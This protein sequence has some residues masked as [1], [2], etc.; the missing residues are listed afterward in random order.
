MSTIQEESSTDVGNDAPESQSQTTS[1]LDQARK[2]QRALI[3]AMPSSIAN[4]FTRASVFLPV[5]S[6][7]HAS[8][9]GNAPLLRH[10]TMSEL[11]PLTEGE[12]KSKER[13]GQL[14]HPLMGR[15][16]SLGHVAEHQQQDTDELDQAP[17]FRH[18]TNVAFST[19]DSMDELD[20]APLLR[21]ETYSGSPAHGPHDELAQA[22]LMRFETNL[23]ADATDI[24]NSGHRLSHDT[25]LVGDGDDGTYDE[26]VHAPLLRHETEPGLPSSSTQSTFNSEQMVS[27][28][29]SLS[30]NIRPS[31]YRSSSVYSN[32]RNELDRAPTLA[33]EA[34]GSADQHSC[35]DHNR[36]GYPPA[37]AQGAAHCGL[38]DC[39]DDNLGG[40]LDRAPTMSHETNDSLFLENPRADELGADPILPHEAGYPDASVSVTGWDGA[41]SDQRGMDCMNDGEDALLST[42]RTNSITSER[43]R[44]AFKTRIFGATRLPM[45]SQNSSVENE[46]DSGGAPLLAHERTIPINDRSRSDSLSSRGGN[47]RQRT[48][49]NVH[50]SLF[51]NRNPSIFPAQRSSLPH[52]MPQ[53]D[54]DDFDLHDP[55]LEIFPVDRDAVFNRVIDIGNR[56]PEDQVPFPVGGIQSP[57]IESQSCSSV[58]LVPIR[59]SSTMSLQSIREDASEDGIGQT[60]LPSPVLMLASRVPKLSSPSPTLM[61]KG[62]DMITPMSQGPQV[63]YFESK[64]D[65]GVSQEGCHAHAPVSRPL[66]G[67]GTTSEEFKRLE[68]ST[69]KRHGRVFDDMVF[70]PKPAEKNIALPP[71]QS[72]DS[73]VKPGISNES[74]ESKKRARRPHPSGKSDGSRG[75]KESNIAR[76]IYAPFRACFSSRIAR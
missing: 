11:T 47:L 75:Y 52:R 76:S 9:F 56:L 46:L 1:S 69:S 51:A 42:S 28:L 4:G 53:R 15:R 33:H 13:D 25:T 30:S 40:E 27:P 67:P 54:E 73:F 32:D 57:A 65:A 50:F 70:L 38:E 55:S 63:G 16:T 23:D 62:E 44:E 74:G 5:G 10:E 12:P 41:S 49:D 60:Q 48:N 22:P 58:D 8:E 37:Y 72:T 61:S 45:V 43:L 26:L 36:A 20:Q 17:L 19:N 64:D 3:E 66:H 29:D 7:G 68:G 2:Y 59:T 6:S 18:E 21:H 14:Q 24:D 39:S 34:G 71:N 35:F 31:S